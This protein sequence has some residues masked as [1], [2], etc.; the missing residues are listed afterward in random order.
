MM[1]KPLITFILVLISTSV[2]GQTAKRDTIPCYIL[3]PGQIKSE[4]FGGGLYIEPKW[5]VGYKIG[6]SFYYDNMVRVRYQVMIAIP[7]TLSR[8][9]TTKHP[10]KGKKP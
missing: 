2:F 4:E 3:L 8:T 1:I 9:D 10:V 7:I 5:V 6:N